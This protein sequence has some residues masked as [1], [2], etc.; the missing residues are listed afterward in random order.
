MRPIVFVA[1]FAVASQARA[2][3]VGD[4]ISHQLTIEYS[5]LV[6]GYRP[7]AVVRPNGETPVSEVPPAS[8]RFELGLRLGVGRLSA[9]LRPFMLT[10]P[11][12]NGP[13]VVGLH[14]ELLVAPF[15]CE[16]PKGEG[17]WD[18][19]WRKPCVEIGYAH[20]SEHNQD[21][22]T[23]GWTYVNGLLVRLR[24][25]SGDEGKS[26]LWLWGIW[27][28]ASAETPFALT[29]ETD[30]VSGNLENR[31]WSAGLTGN[32]RLGDAGKVYGNMELRSS[33]HG[34]AS[35]GV[36]ARY[37]YDLEIGGAVRDDGARSGLSVP[38]RVGGEIGL[39]R[40]L[41]KAD[42]MGD[43]ALRFALILALPFR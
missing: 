9:D 15:A 8:D 22:G 17:A 31:L 41:R 35:F 30:T 4:T 24:L 12:R 29:A 25:R 16:N 2:E 10:V 34:L 3:Q 21:D 27:M 26:A 7:G 37:L 23:Y 11:D 38:F 6:G 20:R 14:Y 28:P 1:V 33:S 43:G 40:N 19:F 36:I 39:E 42:E 32:F 18:R 5:K 13:N